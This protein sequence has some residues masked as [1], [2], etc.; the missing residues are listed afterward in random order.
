[1][2][3][4]RCELIGIMFQYNHFVTRRIKA[5][6]LPFVYTMLYAENGPQ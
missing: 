3:L 5:F 4:L 6:S 1:M 2:L